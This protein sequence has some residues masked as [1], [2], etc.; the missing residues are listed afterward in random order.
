MA[1][2][3][4]QR[5]VNAIS[6]H[7]VKRVLLSTTAGEAPAPLPTQQPP[8]APTTSWCGAGALRRLSPAAVPL[9]RLGDQ[10]PPQQAAGA[11]AA[12]VPERGQRP[13]T[14]GVLGAWAQPPGA[15][16]SRSTRLAGAPTRCRPGWKRLPR[17]WRQSFG[18]AFWLGGWLQPRLQPCPHLPLWFGGGPGV[19]SP[20][21]Q[22]LG[23]LLGGL[24]RWP[25]APSQAGPAPPRENGLWI[26]GDKL[27][28]MRLT[29]GLRG[30]GLQ[31]HTLITTET[32]EGLG[33]GGP[34]FFF[35]FFPC[36]K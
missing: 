4:R 20:L 13:P 21:Q 32:R 36:F 6:V 28:F 31:G 9:R 34:L 35:P 24:A 1:S 33:Q 25:Q 18:A 3:K 30:R 15:D 11:Q 12:P 16:A 2:R 8:G 29:S 14:L 10:K 5:N 26:E 23:S 22:R 19:A 17:P 27:D 7:F